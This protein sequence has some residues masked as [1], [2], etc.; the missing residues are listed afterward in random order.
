MV[1]AIQKITIKDGVTVML[2]LTPSLFAIAKERGVELSADADNAQAVMELY[3]RIIWLAALNYDAA[4]RM[5][6][7]DLPAFAFKYMDFAVWRS[8]R[9]D[10]FARMVDVAVEALT[11]KTLAELAKDPA[12]GEKKNDD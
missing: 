12:G 4:A 7:P 6:D 9:R 5:D 1:S 11:G 8:Q 3:T 10:E 2:L